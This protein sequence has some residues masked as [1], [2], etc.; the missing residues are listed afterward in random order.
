[1]NPGTN[2]GV[3]SI[4]CQVICTPLVVP[5]PNCEAELPHFGVPRHCLSYP[6][7]ETARCRFRWT[8]PIQ[9][10]AE[11]RAVP[12]SRVSQL[13]VGLRNTLVEGALLEVVDGHA[14]LRN[15]V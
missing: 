13:R 1:M 6:I 10:T 14:A 5:L 12:L 11:S 15:R 9:R 4:G 3:V 7:P 8:D 2:L